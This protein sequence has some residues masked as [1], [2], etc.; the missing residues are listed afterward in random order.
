MQNAGRLDSKKTYIYERDGSRV[1]ARETGSTTRILIGEDY[2][3][4]SLSSYATW[5]EMVDM[6]RHNIA[7]RDAFERVKLIYELA[8]QNQTIDHHPV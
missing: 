8:R 6:S 5:L 2:D 1:Y 7:L 4:N 3:P